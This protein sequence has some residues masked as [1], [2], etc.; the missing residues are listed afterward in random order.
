MTPEKY[1]EWARMH[2][3]LFGLRDAADARLVSLWAPCL[4]PF[5]F[6][7]LCDASYAVATDPRDARRFRENHLSMLREAVLAKRA[8]AAA[9][10]CDRLDTMYS[11][12]ECS[13]CF[14]VGLV[15]VPHP[16]WITGGELTRAFFIAVACLCP[17]GIARF[18]SINCRLAEADHRIIDLTQY[19]VLCPDWRQILAARQETQAHEFE[20]AEL[21]RKVDRIAPINPADIKKAGYKG[22]S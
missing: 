21:A 6:E 1:A 17:V 11:R 3:E 14:G 13:D 9:R 8:E 15:R 2:A 22:K 5:D 18:N 20:V 12:A 16:D 4:M 7:E 10:E 19:E